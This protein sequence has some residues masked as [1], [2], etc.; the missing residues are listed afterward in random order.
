[1][2]S[3]VNDWRYEYL[4]IY[5]GVNISLCAYV[6]YVTGIFGWAVAG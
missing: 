5:T 3:Y 1:M 4:Y 2:F 6:L